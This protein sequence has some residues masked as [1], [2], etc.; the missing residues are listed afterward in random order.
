MLR[1]NGHN[2]RN[3]QML[4]IR[5]VSQHNNLVYQAFYRLVPKTMEQSSY[6]AEKSN[7]ARKL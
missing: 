4:S 1:Q 2:L 3:T 5:E 7:K 6:Q